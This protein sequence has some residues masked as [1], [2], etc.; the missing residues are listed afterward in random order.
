[1]KRSIL[2]TSSLLFAII[3]YPDRY[4]TR[5]PNPGE[6]YFLGPTFTS[7]GLYYSTDYGTTALCVDSTIYEAMTITADKTPGVVYYSTMLEALYVSY[8]Y[9]NAGSWQ[10]RN[11]GIML[12][13]NSGLVEGQIYSSFSK[14]S[15]DYGYNFINH[16][17]NGFFG[18]KKDVEI[19][20]YE[21]IGYVI[22]N[23]FNVNDTLYLLITNDNFENL[24]IQNTLPMWSTNVVR[25]SRGVNDGEI[26]LFNKNKYRLY[27][28]SDFGLNWL[29]IN[30]FN[31][32]YEFDDIVGGRIDGELYILF[33]EINSLWQNANTYILHSTDY[34]ISYEVNH[35]FTQG[36]EPLL[37]N[38][39]AKKEDSYNY[40][41]ITNSTD[42]IYYPTGEIPLT[43][44]FYNYS[45]GDINQYEWDFENDGIIDSY[46]EAPLHTYADT[47]WYSVNLTIYDDYDTNSFLRENYVYAYKLTGIYN[48]INIEFNCYPNPFSNCIRFDFLHYPKQSLITIYDITGQQITTLNKPVG[49]NKIV[50]F[51][52]DK[53]GYKIKPGV[54]YAKLDN[55]TFFHK[56]ILTD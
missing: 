29:F 8:N 51:G 12:Q 38:F 13:I 5:G 40:E 50:W 56:L 17:Y 34:G 20:N 3:S 14:H 2:L 49:I 44:Q 48:K 53:N 52:K 4:I 7:E 24:T 42:S 47:G 35:P 10:F 11:G 36:Q 28:S 16:S 18:S 33:R 26:F 39:S 55:N 31:Q 41:L 19:D 30:S 32:T 21:N 22:V 46:E 25:L 45:I 43:V 27:Y 6:I 9:G 54:Y 15:N 1:M 23:N 37:A